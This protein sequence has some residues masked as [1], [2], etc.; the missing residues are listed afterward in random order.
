MAAIG[1]LENYF[2]LVFAEI[3]IYYRVT[4]VLGSR[5]SYFTLVLQFDRV[6]TFNSKTAATYSSQ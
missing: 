6:L 1:H 3:A 4:V 2:F 5:N